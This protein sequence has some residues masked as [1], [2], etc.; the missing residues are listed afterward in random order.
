MRDTNNKGIKMKYLILIS[1]LSISSAQ[2]EQ[3]D[4]GN[5]NCRGCTGSW[6]E[7]ANGTWHCSGT[8]GPL[9]LCGQATMGPGMVK[10]PLTSPMIGG[11]PRKAVTAPANN[12]PK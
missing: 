1:L 4:F 3:H 12:R 5:G 9:E 11:G 2:A 6:S 10:S 7:N 8:A